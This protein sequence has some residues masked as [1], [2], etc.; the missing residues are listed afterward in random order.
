MKYIESFKEY[1]RKRKEEVKYNN[2]VELN[3][4]ILNAVS[5][6]CVLILF[7]FIG[8]VILSI[9]FSLI[10]ILGWVFWIAPISVIANI[11]LSLYK[12]VANV[13]IILNLVYIVY[14]NIQKE[15]AVYKHINHIENELPKNPDIDEGVEKTKKELSKSIEISEEYKE[16]E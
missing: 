13:L 4:K 3:T 1:Y 11:V 6:M 8:S 10:L 15:L 16:N 12:T 5:L 2:Y 7:F 14:L 9:F